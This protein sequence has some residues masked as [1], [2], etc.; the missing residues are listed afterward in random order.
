MEQATL[1]CPNLQRMLS[2]GVLN[3]VMSRASSGARLFKYH[4]EWE[5]AR[6]ARFDGPLAVAL[7][8]ERVY[9]A[10]HSFD[11]LDMESEIVFFSEL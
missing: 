10:P 2:V 1:S 11:S 8:S 9:S 3:S 6:S 5:F 4:H 7:A